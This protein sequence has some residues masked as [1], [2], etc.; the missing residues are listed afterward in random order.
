[1]QRPLTNST[2]GTVVQRKHVLQKQERLLPY[3][4]GTL[5][6]ISW[7]PSC[8]PSVKRTKGLMQTCGA[9]AKRRQPLQPNSDSEQGRLPIDWSSLLNEYVH[10][11]TL[12][13]RVYCSLCRCNATCA[14]VHSPG[15]TL[16]VCSLFTSAL[17]A[18]VCL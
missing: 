6:K 18:A 13:H 1:M 8:G 17:L 10:I 14:Y 5:T 3:R 16:R 7:T 9:I 11:C 15:L 12:L 2:L 4:T